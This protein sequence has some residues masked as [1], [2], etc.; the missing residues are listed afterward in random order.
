MTFRQSATNALFLAAALSAA[1]AAWAQSN[2]SPPAEPEDEAVGTSDLH[3]PGQESSPRRAWV[4][5][6]IAP[7][8][9]SHN[10]LGSSSRTSGETNVSLTFVAVQ[11]LSRALEIEIDVGPSMTIDTDT[12]APFDSSLAA[13]FELRTR[14]AASGFSSF[15]SYGV[16]R[17]FDDFFGAGLDTSQMLKAGAR[18]SGKFGPMAVG[19]ELAPRWVNSSHDLDDYVAGELWMEGVLPVLRDGIDFIAEGVIDRR[20]YLN[21]DPGFGGK[22]RDWRFEAFLGLDF[23][24][25]VSP[26]DGSL[27]RSLGVGLRWLDIHSNMDSVDGSSLKLLPAV[28][29]RLGL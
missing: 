23:A 27:L 14:K 17:D 20:W 24:R 3:L 2:P 6:E 16:A 7:E 12:D 28:T 8:L 29:L 4:D 13:N 5:L 19:F 1:S 26:R 21:M 11:P 9:A 10:P 22:R 18:Y 25:T 15:V